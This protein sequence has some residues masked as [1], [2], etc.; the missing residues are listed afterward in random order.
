MKLFKY[1][2][3]EVKVAPEAMLLTPFKK[4]WTR[5]KSSKKS[6]ATQ[7]L[8]FLYFYCDPR[9]DYQYIT[10]NENRMKAVKQGIGFPDDWK[11]DSVLQ[12]AIKFYGTFDSHAAMLMRLANQGIDKVKE[13][14]DSLSPTDTG[15]AKKA[16]ITVVKEYLSVLELIPK[17]ASMLKEAEKVLYTEEE[18]SEASGSM[19]KTVCDD[20]LD[21]FMS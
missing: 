16:P 3:Y 7:E 17:V 11:P 2:N 9:S 19:E 15:E 12:A 18:S 4:I 1:D 13:V 20:G 8:S 21:A 14:M 5:D 6:K 10:D